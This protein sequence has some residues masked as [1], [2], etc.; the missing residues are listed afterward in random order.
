MLSDMKAKKFNKVFA[1]KLDRISRSVKD[2]EIFFETLQKHNCE[3]ELKDGIVD[4]RGSNGMMYIRM[5]A[6][7]SQ[8]EREVIKER[9]LGGVEA[10]AFKG[11]FGGKPSLGYKKVES[12]DKNGIKDK[13]WII[14][15]EEAD[16]VK[17]IFSECLKGKTCFQISKI[18]KE[19]YPKIFACY[20]KDKI[21]GDR[22]KVYRSWT[23]ASI[24]KILNNP[25]YIGIY[26]F[27]KNVKDK[28][29]IPIEGFVPPLI[30][31]ETFYLCQ[32]Q[33]QK[34]SRN[35]YRSKK[36]LFP[37]KIKCPKCG[38]IMCC[39]GTRKSNQQE[40]LY[41]KCKDC[42]E[43]VREDWAET[44]MLKRLNDLLEFNY[45][46]DSSFVPV[47]SESAKKFNQGKHNI[48]FALDEKTIR[49]KQNIYNFDK[50]VETWNSLGYECKA[51]FIN[52][53]IDTIE[54]NKQKN[55]SGSWVNI[56]NFTLRKTK[57]S[58]IFELENKKLIDEIVSKD[59]ACEYSICQMEK[60]EEANQYIEL[61]RAKY[62]IKTIEMSNED[63]WNKFWIPNVI[64][65]I[66]VPS[67]KAIQKPK[68]IVVM[69]S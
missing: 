53:C 21:T 9:T 28:E 39:N 54:I 31:E 17:E 58:Q 22:Y 2:L 51:D 38:R 56:I 15:K 42:K 47:D 57:L 40:Y 69:A 37:P 18:M 34:N 29:T 8:F 26:E 11:H 61:L 30:S 24:S 59:T 35:Y 60:E 27:R 4:F 52:Q 43:Y 16:I 14:N 67:K 55:K 7:Y 63:M 44:A 41:Y 33:L 49:D 25:H 48:R 45:A 66:K 32:E 46:L 5:M 6:V 62:N 12:E 36:Y 64:K 10:V 13:E 20:R 19:K 23:D 50:L 3:L 1:L 68:Y 65:K